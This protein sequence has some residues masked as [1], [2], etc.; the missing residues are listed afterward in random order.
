MSNDEARW[1]DNEETKHV[2]S[3][4][5][6]GTAHNDVNASYTFLP[7]YHI[8]SSGSSSN[9]D[10]QISIINI[11]KHRNIRIKRDSRNNYNNFYD[12]TTDS[13]EP[14]SCYHHHQET[15]HH[16]SRKSSNPRSCYQIINVCLIVMLYV[17]CNFLV[18]SVNCDELMDAAGARG[19]FTH[20]WAVHIPGGE[21]VA[22][23]VAD[24]HGMILR[25]KVSRCSFLGCN[26]LICFMRVDA[27]RYTLFDGFLSSLF[28]SSLNLWFMF[29]REKFSVNSDGSILKSLTFRECF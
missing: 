4:C 24:D 23:M 26:L 13:I 7:V 27:M 12:V 14:A 16:S 19:H 5:I 25:G 11:H 21:R 28:W 6:D 1:C 20:T 17:V 10:D 18:T 29:Q 15:H 3:D 2:H 22:R 8:N 9:D